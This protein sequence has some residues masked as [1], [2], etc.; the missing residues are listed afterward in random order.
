MDCSG[1]PSLWVSRQTASRAGLAGALGLRVRLLPWGPAWTRRALPYPS[2]EWG[3]TS[4]LTGGP[5][6]APGTRISFCDGV[7]SS[8]STVP[9]LPPPPRPRR[10]TTC[11]WTVHPDAASEAACPLV[12]AHPAPPVSITAGVGAGAVRPVQSLG[13]VGESRHWGCSQEPGPRRGRNGDPG[14]GK[15]AEGVPAARWQPTGST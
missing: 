4:G 14:A 10:P 2:S 11:T 15:Q 1:P 8:L 3:P 7:L 5:S 6:S 12:P 9:S 13:E